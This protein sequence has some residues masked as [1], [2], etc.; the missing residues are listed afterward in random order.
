[1][2]GRQ[3]GRVSPL[4]LNQLVIHLEE[5]GRWAIYSQPAEMAQVWTR[6]PPSDGLARCIMHIR[7]ILACGLLVECG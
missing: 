7:V 3:E 5:G 4:T 1:M 2:L 6:H